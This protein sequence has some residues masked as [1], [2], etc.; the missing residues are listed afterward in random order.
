M[1]KGIWA[2]ILR[3]GD[4]AGNF[5]TGTKIAP[6]KYALDVAIKEGTVSG[7]VDLNSPG[8]SGV[9]T[10]VTGV[11]TAGWTAIPTT[12]LTSRKSLTIQNNSNDD[13]YLSFDSS[14]SNAAIDNILLGSGFE[15]F[16]NIADGLTIY[17][18]KDSG[19][20]IDLIVEE[21]S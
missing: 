18:R 19:A 13:C 11:G 16:Y 9:T 3:F 8:T 5:I 15:R 17:A 6:N 20:D 2:K 21:I 7:D 10:K 1:N 12:A 4:V 14:G